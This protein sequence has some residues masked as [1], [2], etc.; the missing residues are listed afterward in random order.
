MRLL[1]LNF[2]LV[3]VD[4]LDSTVVIGFNKHR[5]MLMLTALPRLLILPLNSVPAFHAL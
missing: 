5:S 3:R 2:N 4:F 1:S